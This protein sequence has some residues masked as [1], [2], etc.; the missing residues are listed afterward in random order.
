[1]NTIPGYIPSNTTPEEV[2]ARL[3]DWLPPN[4]GR[5]VEEAWECERARIEE[6]A[7]EESYQAGYEAGREAVDREA[8]DAIRDALEALASIPDDNGADASTDRAIADA[9]KALRAVY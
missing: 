3:K 1:M 4:V 2:L 8:Y 7:D 6:A 9:I 5:S